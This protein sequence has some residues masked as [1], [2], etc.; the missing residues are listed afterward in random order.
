MSRPAFDVVEVEKW[1]AARQ[2]EAARKSALYAIV[3]G[4]RTF[5]E[6]RQHTG[7][8]EVRCALALKQLREMHAIWDGPHGFVGSD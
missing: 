4:A 3:R 8:C 5:A 7:L 2:H 6:V 1:P